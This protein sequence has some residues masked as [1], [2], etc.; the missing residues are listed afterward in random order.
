M[1]R[2]VIEFPLA[3]ARLRSS[4]PCGHPAEIIIFPGVRFERLPDDAMPRRP[5]R[6]RRTSRQMRTLHP[7]KTHP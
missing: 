6:R 4:A 2:S 1:M 7:E 5:V 3:L